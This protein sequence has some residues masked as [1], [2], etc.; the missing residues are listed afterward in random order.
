MHNLGHDGVVFIMHW[1]IFNSKLIG[2][3]IVRFSNCF[4][5]VPVPATNT[6]RNFSLTYV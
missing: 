5:I 4:I 1:R 3:T 6:V 2:I